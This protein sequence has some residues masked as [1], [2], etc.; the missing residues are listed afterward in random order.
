MTPASTLAGASLLLL[1]TDVPPRDLDAARLRSAYRSM[2]KLTHPD[3]RRRH[4][5]PDFLRVREAFE[6]LARY[7]RTTGA[8]PRAATVRG[9]SAPPASWYWKARVPDRPLRFGEFLF[10]SG[11]ISWDA[12][13]GAIVEQKG[14]RPPLG[15]LACRRGVLSPEELATGIERRLRGE[16]LGDALVRLGLV[17]RT[18]VDRLLVEQRLLQRPLGW[19]LSRMGSVAESDIPAFLSALWRHNAASRRKR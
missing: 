4:G 7:V 5:M 17:P 9:A 2:A 8:R 14:S 12:L 6:E 15:R 13:I 1:G 3:T 10:Y 18:G 19:H 11:A 16:L